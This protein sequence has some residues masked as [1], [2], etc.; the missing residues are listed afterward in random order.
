[1]PV[2]F[3]KRQVRVHLKDEEFSLE[4]I[5]IGLDAG[6]YRLASAGHLETAD[7]TRPV[8]GEVWVPRE[9]VLYLQVIG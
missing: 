2:F 1:M 4:G 8:A 3:R 9:K 6:H 5:W 7:R